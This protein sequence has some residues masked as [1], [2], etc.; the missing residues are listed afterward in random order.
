M[1]ILIEMEDGSL[2]NIEVQ[3]TGYKIHQL[4]I[5]Q[6]HRAANDRRDAG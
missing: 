2:A 1:D 6:E 3:K 5:G 4:N